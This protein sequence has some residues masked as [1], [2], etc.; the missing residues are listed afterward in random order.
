MIRDPLTGLPFPGNV[1]PAGRITPDG[2]AIA[3]LYTQM[4]GIANS[5]TD[6]ATANNSLFQ[7]ANPFRWRQEMVRLDYNLSP[8]HRLTGRLLLDHYTLTDPYG[9]F[10]GG[11]L[12]TTPTDRNRARAATSSSTTCG[13]SQPTLMNEAKFNYSGNGQHIDPVG[14]LWA[15]STYGFQ[16]P[17]IYTAGGNFEDAIPI[18]TITGYAGVEQR[19]RGARLPDARLGLQRHRHLAPGQPH[20]EGRAALRLQHEEAERPLELHRHAELHHHGQH[21]D[22]RAGVRRRAARQLPQLQRGAARPARL[23][24]LPPG[25]GVRHRRLAR[26]AQRSASRWACATRTTTRPTPKA[27]T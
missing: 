3:N 1:I 15:R 6:T 10:I 9:V 17:Q 22:L 13:R 20:R 25:R 27:T 24:R 5:Y 14:D 26:R 18:T 4:A 21:Q 16:Y 7:M 11:D 23:L 2:Q 19:Q 8:K 12:P